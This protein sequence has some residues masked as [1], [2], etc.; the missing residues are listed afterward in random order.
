MQITVPDC[1]PLYTTDRVEEQ[2]N[3]SRRTRLFFIGD[4][5][6]TARTEHR[7]Q[8][9]DLLILRIRAIIILARGNSE[10]KLYRCTKYIPFWYA[11]RSWGCFQHTYYV[12]ILHMQTKKER[13]RITHT[14][15]IR[16]RTRIC[17]YTFTYLHIRKTYFNYTCT[18]TY[19][20]QIC[21]HAF[22]RSQKSNV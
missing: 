3:F 8:Y 19:T 2:V 9:V 13:K 10:S 18:H 6:C 7:S 12:C 22:C 1:V 4:K 21:K 17:I 11:G 20:L 14:W 15:S 16:T 5:A